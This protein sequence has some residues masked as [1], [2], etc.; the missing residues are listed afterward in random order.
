MNE[1][2][3]LFGRATSA[4]AR[5]M[6][7][8]SSIVTPL[9]S[10]SGPPVWLTRAAPQ[11]RQCSAPGMDSS[12]EH[13]GQRVIGPVIGSAMRAFWTSGV[14]CLSPDTP[15]RYSHS[16]VAGGLLLM[17]YT[18]R[19]TPG[20]SFTIRLTDLAQD[21][22]RQL[23]PVGG[24]A[25]LGRHGA[26]RHDVRVGPVVAHDAHRTDGR[27]DRERLPDAAVEPR[28][29]DLV[30][31]DPVRVAQRVE[32]LS[33]DLADDPDREPRARERLALDHRLRQAHLGAHH[34][35]PRP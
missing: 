9:I 22:V 23:R 17:S 25:V 32:A 5:R 3:R 29:L 18:T 20:T 4:R 21:V 2:I 11:A 15:M 35:G 31:D 12:A 1:R 10:G 28:G 33:G 13:H 27:E 7:S 24:H 6:A 19:L 26:D 16:I 30:D 34:A 14:P 8:G